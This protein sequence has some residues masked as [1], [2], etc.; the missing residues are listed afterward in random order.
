VIEALPNATVW[1]GKRFYQRHDIHMNDFYYWD[2]SGPGGG[3]ENIDLGFGRLSVAWLR[4]SSTDEDFPD[5]D[6]N[7]ANDTL[8]IR[9]AGLK[10]NPGGE[11]EIGYDYGAANLTDAQEEADV[12]PEKGH[13]V[14][15]EHVQGNWLGGYNKFVVQYGKDGAI[16][17]SGKSNTASSVPEGD[18]MRVLDHGL[19]NLSPNVDMLYAAIYED[20]DLDNGQ[21]QTW[22][23]AGLRPTY[24]WSD[25]MSTAMELGY[26]RVDPQDNSR[27]TAH[28]TKLTLAQQWSAGRGAFARPVVRAF[29]TYAKW[30]GEDYNA[31]SESV[32]D[33]E[34]NGM[35]YGLQMEAWW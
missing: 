13:L 19:V 17:S 20:R 1:A 21:G 16:G 30:N 34:D 29:V 22:T 10:T 32:D 8:D 28:L 5:S 12:D 2:V 9:L 25:T 14:T 6:Q 27:E 11:L 4:N 35:T 23:S 18:M 15:L 26:D 3:I 7:L 31:A 24:Y 33:L